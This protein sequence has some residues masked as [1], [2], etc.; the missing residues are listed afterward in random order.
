MTMTNHGPTQS[1]PVLITWLKKAIPQ[2]HPRTHAALRWCV[3]ALFV[4]KKEKRTEKG[5]KH[6]FHGI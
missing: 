1:Q 4:R 5:E 6:G 2:Q 3:D